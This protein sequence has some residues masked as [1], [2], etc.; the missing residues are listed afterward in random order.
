[1]PIQQSTKQLFRG[2]L[3]TYCRRV[4][5]GITTFA[6]GYGLEPPAL[7]RAVEERGFESLFFPEHT[8]I[9]VRSKRTDGRPTRTYAETYDPFV[10][11]SAVAAVTTGI[12]IGTGV[13]LV[14]Q[15][16][17]IVTAKEVACLDRW[18]KPLRRPHPPVLVGGNG[19]GTEDRVL[20]FGDGWL[21]Q[22]SGL[23][24]IA[25]LKQRAATLRQLAAELGRGRIPI[26][27]FNA[28]PDAGSLN[29]L[30]DA[31]IDRCLLLLPAAT[32]SELLG[33]LDAW[34]PLASG[35]RRSA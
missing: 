28:P 14:T 11:L 29:A 30:A 18:P 26:T 2:L 23:A 4:D 10:A 22:C 27:V 24:G 17:P 16:D 15:R 31:G 7:G 1:V 6:G 13:C 35:Q 33:Q 21:P 3:S 32:E 12:T 9:P 8:H 5:V 25:E 34:A 20:A 19:P